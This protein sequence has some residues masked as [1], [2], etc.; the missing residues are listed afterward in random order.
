MPAASEEKT[1]EQ[2]ASEKIEASAPEA[3]DK[4][5]D[6]IIRHASGKELSQCKKKS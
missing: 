5:I 3:S 4:D 2:I 1:I 6:Y